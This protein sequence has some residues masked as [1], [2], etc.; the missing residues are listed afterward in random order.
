MID[1]K[2]ID[3][4][5]ELIMKD[6]SVNATNFT[7]LKSGRISI[8]KKVSDRNFLSVAYWDKDDEMIF[9]DTNLLD[10]IIKYIPLT[11]EQVKEHF[12]V[13]FKNKYADQIEQ[14]KND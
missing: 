6:Y 13:W 4:L 5:M 9:Y 10:E 11:Y 7:Y 1:N 2:V 8:T 3:K 12:L 14:L